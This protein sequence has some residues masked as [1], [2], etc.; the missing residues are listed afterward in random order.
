MMRKLERLLEKNSQIIFSISRFVFGFLF[1]CHGSQKLFSAFGGHGTMGSPKL[2]LG[3]IIEFSG[4]IL[5][6]I[7]LKTRYAAVITAL[8]MAYAYSTVHAHM[9]TLPIENGGELAVLYFFFFLFTIA[10]GS[11]S[12]SVDSLLKKK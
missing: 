6:G 3:G 11:G 5:I 12:W 9:G 10:N 7:G 2:L 4:G 8:E 1:F